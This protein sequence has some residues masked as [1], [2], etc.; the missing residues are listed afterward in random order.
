MTL[1]P[2]VNRTTAVRTSAPHR[3]KP[4]R[5]S[6]HRRSGLQRRAAAAARPTIQTGP[7]IVDR[8]LLVELRDWTILAGVSLAGCMV[9]AIAI[10]A[11]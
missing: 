4:T 10:G 3:A 2:K 11:V 1:S 7:I 9:A 6:V 8:A 5:R